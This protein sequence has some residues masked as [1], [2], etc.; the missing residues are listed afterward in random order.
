MQSGVRLITDGMGS[1]LKP[2]AY[3]LSE[4]SVPNYTVT[5]VNFGQFKFAQQHHRSRGL[6]QPMHSSTYQD[7]IHE[8]ATL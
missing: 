8:N 5:D 3:C 7:A 1:L 2:T 6:S 4:A